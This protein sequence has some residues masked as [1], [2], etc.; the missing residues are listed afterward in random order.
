VGLCKKRDI[1]LVF[2][3]AN[4]M[5][6]GG[7]KTEDEKLQDKLNAEKALMRF[8]FL[9]VL[10]RLA[11][12]KYIKSGETADVSDSLKMLIT[13]N[14][15]G[16]LPEESRHDVDIFRRTRLYRVRVEALLVKNQGWLTKI[17]THY[18]ASS[19]DGADIMDGNKSKLLSMD[20]WINF[21]Y[22]VGLVDTEVPE[23]MI[24]L[25]YIWSQTYVTDEIKKREKLTNAMIVDFYEMICRLCTF[26]SLP[27]QSHLDKADVKSTNEFFDVVRNG[28]VEEANM[29]P[30]LDYRVE[31][32][33]TE[34]L[35]PALEKML[36]LIFDRLDDDKD[37]K[38][39]KEDMKKLGNGVE[40]AR[41]ANAEILQAQVKKGATG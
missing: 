26:K 9:Q 19:D 14:L 7:N 27:T 20:E 31:E 4:V 17:F 36:A 8:E 13:R 11:V 10:I 21:A 25:C 35:W 2:I 16:Q 34:P 29:P 22:D 18:A 39:G 41:I 1:D 32:A 37:G 12:N 5:E 40:G 6:K 30:K 15:I 23:R 33:S 28:L 24:R 38:L 3:T